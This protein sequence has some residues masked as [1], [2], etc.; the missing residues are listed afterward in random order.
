M[1]NNPI[2]ILA[3]SMMLVALA[4]PMYFLQYRVEDLHCKS[5]GDLSFKCWPGSPETLVVPMRYF[6][7]PPDTYKV[8]GI[9]T[10][11]GTPSLLST[12]M[13][14]YLPVSCILATFFLIFRVW[15]RRDRAL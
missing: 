11:N 15:R 2:A 13:G 10:R 7:F 8:Y 6:S 1:K 12:V 4:L 14:V 3:L 5:V 9:Y